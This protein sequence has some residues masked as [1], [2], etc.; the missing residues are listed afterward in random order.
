MDGKRNKS[1]LLVDIK[2]SQLDLRTFADQLE[3]ALNDVANQGY[4]KCVA[5]L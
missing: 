2:T 5:W 1:R 3:Q 4:I